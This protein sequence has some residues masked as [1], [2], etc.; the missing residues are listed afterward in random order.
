MTLFLADGPDSNWIGFLLPLVVVTLSMAIP[1]IAIITEHFQKKDKTRLL[2]KA[3]EHGID[4]E[5]LELEEPRKPH[6]PYRSGMIMVAVGVAL[7]LSDQLGGI[8]IS[9]IRFPLVAAGLIVGLI[10]V[11]LLVNDRMNRDRLDPPER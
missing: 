7:G 4:P 1:I 2:E 8:G 3:I 9:G 6:L 11:A 10:G 5:H